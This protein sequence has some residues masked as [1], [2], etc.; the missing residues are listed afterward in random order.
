MLGASMAV[1]LVG[2]KE[3]ELLR[4]IIYICTMGLM[5]SILCAKNVILMEMNEMKNNG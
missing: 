5:T 1:D 3:G 4:L 2:P